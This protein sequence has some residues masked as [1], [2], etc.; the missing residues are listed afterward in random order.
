MKESESESHLFGGLLAR[1]Q[2]SRQF[3]TFASIACRGLRTGNRRRRASQEEVQ[4]RRRSVQ[5]RVHEAGHQSPARAQRVRPL[6]RRAAALRHRHEL[7]RQSG[8][9]R[10]RCTDA[11]TFRLLQR[12]DDDLKSN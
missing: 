4:S 2:H 12:S 1:S 5:E 7:P 9:V 10:C 8:R 11:L 3:T 6:R